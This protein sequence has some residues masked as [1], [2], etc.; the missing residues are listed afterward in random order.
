[1]NSVSCSA[2]RDQ[3]FVFSVGRL[4]LECAGCSG[5]APCSYFL[6]FLMFNVVFL[7]SLFLI[8]FSLFLVLYF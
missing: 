6:F 5:D 3:R 2:F 1:M 8:H 7:I 4:E